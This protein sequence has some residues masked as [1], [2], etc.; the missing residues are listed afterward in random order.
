M[1]V[2]KHFYKIGVIQVMGRLTLA[3]LST[4]EIHYS[5][6]TAFKNTHSQ[7]KMIYNIKSSSNEI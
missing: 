7:I 2:V 5:S 6:G 4:T 3:I 1:L